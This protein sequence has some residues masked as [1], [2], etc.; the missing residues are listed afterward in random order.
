MS[1]FSNIV[2]VSDMDGTFLGKGSR[3]VPENVEAIRYFSNNG[4]RF[5]FIT[6]RNYPA[7]AYMDGLFD[8]VSAPIGFH[9]GAHIYDTAKNETVE[10]I[11]IPNDVLVELIDYLA[12]L[13]ESIDF[14]LRCAFSF[15][16]IEGRSSRDYN[17]YKE[18]YH[19]T[20]IVSRDDL[21]T[22]RVNKVVF[23]GSEENVAPIRRHIENKFGQQLECTSAGPMYIEIMPKSIS[24]ATVI[25]KLRKLPEYSDAVF[26]AIGDY[27]NDVEMIKTAD[28]GACPENAMAKVQSAAKIHVCH[29]DKGAIADLIRI[30]EEK[31]IV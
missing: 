22:L 3:I 23:S 15:C 10:E 17:I 28:Y 26:F 14:T 2:I 20:E 6:G 25:T 1:K 19:C 18:Y 30:I 27:E 4:G 12:D 13:P 11:C 8:I 9:N 31:Y 21:K 24:K 29:H 7:V 5:T 16:G